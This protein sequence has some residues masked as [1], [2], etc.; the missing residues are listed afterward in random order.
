M[1][2]V[3]VANHGPPPS[4]RFRYPG[5]ASSSPPAQRVPFAPPPPRPK[6]EL[7]MPVVR[8]ANHGMGF[9]DLV[10]DGSTPFN[11]LHSSPGIPR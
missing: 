5:P 6:Q 10:A 1:P 9:F 4:R 2:A 7:L 11:I 3:R 8:V